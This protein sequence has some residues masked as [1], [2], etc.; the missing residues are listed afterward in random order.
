MLGLKDYSTGGYHFNFKMV[1]ALRGA[2]HEA[3]VIH[4]TAIPEKLRG[5]RIRGS[6]YVLSRVLRNK[7]D[8]LVVSKSYSFM[9]P[10][11]L[12]LPVLRCPVL[13]M[14]HHLE[15]HDRSEGVSSFRKK[16]V[17]WFL[18]CG[19]KIW[20][21][22]LSTAADVV[23]LGIP[24]SRLCVIPPGFD[25]F[26]T[27]SE[28]KQP[29]VRILSVGTICP[30]KDQLTLVKAC[31]LLGDR[32]FHLFIPG[33]DTVDRNYAEAVRKEADS[34]GEKVT[35]M[36]HLSTAELY[37]MYNQSHILANLSHWEGYG[38]AV[39]EAMWA[40]L[41]VVAVDAGAVPELV[42]HGDNGYLMAPGDVESC[43]KYL[44]ELIDNGALREKMSGSARERAGK[45]F[46][47]RDTGREFVNLAEE[48][49][50]CK[51]RRNQSG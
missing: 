45:L 12:I 30:R 18:S 28:T 38:I 22:S 33:D 36:G 40:G 6:F 15:W 39:A 44:K 9:A 32:D 11:R 31:A 47:W 48:T 24:E 16:T 34:L 46:T 41:P 14:V 20:V 3:D 8:L 35:F 25:R 50:G 21:N 27:D 26:R 7:P 51:I 37:S 49:A 29:P 23:T 13:Y 5:S 4:F 10:L 1:N 17:K 19:K 2:G 43:A 42:T